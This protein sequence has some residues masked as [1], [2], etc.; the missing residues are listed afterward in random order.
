MSPVAI[1]TASDSGIGQESAKALAENGFDVGITYHEDEAGARETL[2]AVEAAGRRGEIRHLDL[3]I[4]PSA[5]NVID[6]LADSLRAR[7]KTCQ[8]PL[9]L[10]TPTDQLRLPI[11]LLEFAMPCEMPVRQF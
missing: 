2:S 3:T 5:A 6:E 7:F 1:V 8:S 4:L 10:R 9:R 11:G